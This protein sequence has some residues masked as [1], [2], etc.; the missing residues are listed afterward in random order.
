MPDF[1]IFQYISILSGIL[2]CAVLA[3]VM[4]IS[5]MENE[6]RA[7]IRAVITLFPVI[8][9]YILPVYSHSLVTD[10]IIIVVVTL[11]W[12]SVLLLIFP[13]QLF[14]RKIHREIPSGKIN[15]KTLMFSR[16]LYVPGT[17]RY[18]DYYKEFPEHE[19]PDNIFRSKPGDFNLKWKF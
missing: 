6:K 17:E 12:F 8:L 14:E 5:M 1:S 19:A 18:H 10:H 13:T 15:E 2:L 16:N 4:I 3:Y 7:A 11:T 9:I